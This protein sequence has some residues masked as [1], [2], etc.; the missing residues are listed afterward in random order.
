MVKSIED[1]NDLYITDGQGEFQIDNYGCY[2]HTLAL[3]LY[4]SIYKDE[5]FK[6]LI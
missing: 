2:C 3:G 6:N 5:Q 1:L 4:N